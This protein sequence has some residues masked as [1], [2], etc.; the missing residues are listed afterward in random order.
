MY[1]AQGESADRWKKAEVSTLEIGK[2]RSSVHVHV[3]VTTENKVLLEK[4]VKIRLI[5][6]YVA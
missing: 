1:T 3:C 5:H 6:L 2:I 4:E